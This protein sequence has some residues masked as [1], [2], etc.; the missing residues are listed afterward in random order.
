MSKVFIKKF[1]ILTIKVS[2]EDFYFVEMDSLHRHLSNID[3]LMARNA[4]L[5]CFIS[6]V[7][8]HCKKRKRRRRSSLAL[9][10]QH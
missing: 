4:C 9:E 6:I 7:N 8:G 2:K 1:E 3:R 5:V 10:D